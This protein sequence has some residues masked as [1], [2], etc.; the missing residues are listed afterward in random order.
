[1]PPRTPSYAARRRPEIFF[2]AGGALIVA[3]AAAASIAARSPV[4]PAAVPATPDTVTVRL[5]NGVGYD[6]PA[7]LAPPVLSNHSRL[8]PGTHAAQVVYQHVVE[9]TAAKAGRNPAAVLRDL[10]AS[11]NGPFFPDFERE[12]TADPL[13]RAEA[14]R[15]LAGIV[16][17]A[18]GAAPFRPVGMYG[19][20]TVDLGRC[21]Q[22]AQARLGAAGHFGREK[23]SFWSPRVAVYERSVLAARPPADVERPL[24][25]VADL[26]APSLYLPRGYGVDPARSVTAEVI[27]LETELLCREAG[28]WGRPVVAFLSACYA[29]EPQGRFGLLSREER[30]AQLRG[31]RDAGAT[32]LI[33]IDDNAPPA[34]LAAQRAMAAEHFEVLAEPR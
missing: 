33:W 16:T 30:L 4:P 29:G 26:A 19:Y 8:L 31:A 12:P 13:R 5:A 11:G 7:A 9:Y 34:V 23:V 20:P 6:V 3:L 15:N 25:A 28:R 22:L 24:A 32:A 10:A 17:A 14:Y 27:R 2:L 18:K 21:R 1:M